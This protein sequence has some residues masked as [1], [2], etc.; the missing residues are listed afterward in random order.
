[1]SE[2][3]HAWLPPPSDKPL[4]VANYPNPYPSPNPTPNPNP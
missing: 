1:M 4:K 2:R 3:M